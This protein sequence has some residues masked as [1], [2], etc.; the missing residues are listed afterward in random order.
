[1]S[2]RARHLIALGRPAEALTELAKNFDAEDPQHW[3]LRG[4]ALFGL[5][6]TDEALDAVESGLRVDPE[7]PLLLD[8]AAR[9]YSRR[10]DLVEAERAA[11]AALRLDSEDADLLALYALIVAKAGQIDKARKLIA[12]ARRVDPENAS[13]LRIEAAIAVSR[14]DEREAMLR[15][16]ELLA[17]NPEDSHAH[18]MVGELLHDRGDVDAAAEHLRTAVVNDPSDPVAA[19]IA[20]DNLAWRH[21]LMWPLRPAQRYGAAR[22][23]LA[24][25]VLLMLV[26]ATKNQPLMIT[27]GI[28]WLAYCVYSWVVPPIVRRLVR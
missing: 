9:C 3:W 12:E 6:R 17:L 11:L 16:R 21:P 10:G 20:R 15:G 4:L 25:I 22:V 5:D 19:E 24:G 1:M 14:G 27:V 13:A 8:L 28:A 26:R 2:D 7:S 18:G 23:W